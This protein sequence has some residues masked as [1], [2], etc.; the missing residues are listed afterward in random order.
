[1]SDRAFLFLFSLVVV[2]GVLAFDGWLIVSGQLGT[3]DG[4]FLFCSSLVIAF[5]FGLYVR[6]LVRSAMPQALSRPTRVS[7]Q[8]T[9][10]RSTVNAEATAVLRDVR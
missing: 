9:E 4:L 5:A 1:M 7:T 6:F 10:R 3:I 2:V 8:Q